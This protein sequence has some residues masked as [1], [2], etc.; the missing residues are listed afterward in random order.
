MNAFVLDLHH[1]LA[2]RQRESHVVEGAYRSTLTVLPFRR[3]MLIPI[4]HFTTIFLQ[5]SNSEKYALR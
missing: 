1:R 3:R 5:A 4:L 2:G